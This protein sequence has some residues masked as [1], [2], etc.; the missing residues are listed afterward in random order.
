LLLAVFFVV[1]F[2]ARPIIPP[3][4]TRYLTVAWEMY[5]RESWFVPTLNF[6]PYFQKGP[7]LF[8]LI[9][10]AW[11]IFGVSRAA[12]LV[13]IFA[14]SASIIYLT[15]RLSRCFRMWREW[16]RGRRGFCSAA[17]PS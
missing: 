2:V 15:Q 13:V 6:E 11:E 3:D 4:E 8:W 1:G 10:L 14:I 5:L 16:P 17:S 12:A 7:L 9:D